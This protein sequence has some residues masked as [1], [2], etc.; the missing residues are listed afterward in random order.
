MAKKV[1][2]VDARF[3]GRKTRFKI[4]GLALSFLDGGD[5]RPAAQIFDDLTSRRWRQGDVR[6]VLTAA[7]PQWLAGEREVERHLDDVPPIESAALA[8]LIL[9]ATLIGIDPSRASFD[10]NMESVD[11]EG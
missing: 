9:E 3:L 1:R 5:R 7:H 4:G 2:Y 6:R 8:A 10:P 11:G